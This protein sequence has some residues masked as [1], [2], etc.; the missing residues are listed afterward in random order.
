MSEGP[1]PAA[2]TARL[3]ELQRR[4]AAAARGGG[5]ERIARQHAAGKLTAR[6]RVELLLD[7]ASFVEIDALVTHPCRDFGMANQ[8][9]PGAGGACG[10]GTVDGPPWESF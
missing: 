2:R 3:A 1:S 8:Q 10:H 4:L 9:E 5:T 6:E 7:P